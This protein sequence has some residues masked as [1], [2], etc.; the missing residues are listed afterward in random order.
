MIP[1][2]EATWRS[3][4]TIEIHEFDILVT[5]LQSELIDVMERSSLTSVF[6][7][8]AMKTISLV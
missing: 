4:F 3:F 8:V 1:I 6:C 2:E 5:R 7:I